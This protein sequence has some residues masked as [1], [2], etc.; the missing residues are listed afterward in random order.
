MRFVPVVEGS[1]CVYVP[2]DHALA[3]KSTATIDDL[4]HEQQPLKIRPRYDPHG[5]SAAAEVLKDGGVPFTATSPAD[6]E[7]AIVSMVEAGLGLYPASTWYRRACETASPASPSSWTSSA[8][9]S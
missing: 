9:R 7:E 3:R 5:I 4:A 2:K 8:C 6:N 1:P